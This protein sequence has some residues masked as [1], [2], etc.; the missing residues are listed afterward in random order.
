VVIPKQRAL[1]YLEH[2]WGTYVERFNRLSKEEQK[3]RVTEAGY[4]SFR[5]LLAHVLAW[6][7][8]GMDILH[9]IAEERPFERKKYDFDAFNAGAV[10]KYKPWDE[11]EFLAHFE[12]TR[13]QMAADL[14]SMEE[15]VFE[16]RRV[17]AWLDGMLVHHAREHL[18]ALSRFLA[19]DMLANNWATYIEDFNC[20]EPAAQKEFLAEQGVGSLHDL[21][22]HIIGWWEESA[23]IITGILNSPSFAWQDPDT[24]AFNL[25]LT[26]KFSTWS[27]A[28]LVEHY[29]S[30]R[31]AL[32]DLVERLPEDAFLNKDIEGWLASDVVKHYDDHPIPHR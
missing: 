27:D 31:L 28:D 20:L 17:Q 30:L 2:E 18:L 25:E 26:R 24:D 9:A 11:S 4:T 12:A 13:R 21:L 10:A 32:I 1:A 14:N 29:E 3:E 16:N 7:E 19:V 23:R 6:W 15:A 22:A 8:E 5:D